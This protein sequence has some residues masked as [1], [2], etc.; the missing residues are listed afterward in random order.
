M[1]APPHS[2]DDMVFVNYVLP[3]IKLYGFDI[4]PHQ[5]HSF[6]DS[7]TINIGR[8]QNWVA[9][10][11]GNKTFSQHV[12]MMTLYDGDFAADAF[13]VKYKIEDDNSV[14]VLDEENNIDVSVFPTYDGLVDPNLPISLKDVEFKKN[15]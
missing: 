6:K 2:F 1:N 11:I 5:V 10:L 9:T 8:D 14:K 4:R 12:L 15:D 13:L 7:W 3:V